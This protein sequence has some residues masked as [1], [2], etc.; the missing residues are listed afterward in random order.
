MARNSCRA[1]RKDFIGVY[2]V[3]GWW[4]LRKF[5]GRYDS[6]LRFGLVVT[7]ALPEQEVDLYTEIATQIEATR[8]GRNSNLDR[9]NHKTCSSGEICNRN[10]A[11]ICSQAVSYL[12]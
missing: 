1:S 3:N 9:L 10:K 11:A 12:S 8:G 2:P 5:L 6:T 7:I 4:R